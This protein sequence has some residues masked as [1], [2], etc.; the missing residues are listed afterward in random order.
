MPLAVF[1]P[2]CLVSVHIIPRDKGDS[3]LDHREIQEGSP[4]ACPNI[5]LGSTEWGDKMSYT[6]NDMTIEV[7][8]DDKG[9]ITMHIQADKL[10]F[11]GKFIFKDTDVQDQFFLMPLSND[12]HLYF[13]NRKKFGIQVTG[14]YRYKD[15]NYICNE[16]DHCLGN[17]DNGRGHFQYHTNWYW[18]SFSAYIPEIKKT[19]ALN[20]GDGIA[21]EYTPEDGQK[22]YED[23]LNVGGKL[24]KLDQTDITFDEKDFMKMHTFK[25]IS[26]SKPFPGRKCDLTFTPIGTAKDGVHLTLFGMV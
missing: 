8:K 17:Y 25:T 22:F 6:H 5:E 12:K 15:K 21:V 16:E 26:P 18:A 9:I 2:V 13:A 10:E 4:F 19:V 1:N 7:T 11:N 3:M 14:H 24:Y 20:M 23:F